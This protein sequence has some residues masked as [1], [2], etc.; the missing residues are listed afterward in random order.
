[1]AH[2]SKSV[3]QYILWLARDGAVTPM[4]L[5]KLV[6][7]SHGWMLGLHSQPLLTENAEAW[8]YGPVVP[9]VYHHYKRFGGNT[10]TDVPTSEPSGFTPEEQDLLQ[11]V[12]KTYGK[13]NG[14]QL[15]A[16]THQPG[17]PW[18]I[19]RRL[20]GQGAITPNDLIEEHYRALA[21]KS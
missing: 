16:L 10:I 5:L 12:W 7:L 9:S 13:Y 18:E 1:M 11:Q 20:S 19:T 8:Q 14:L 2:D 3:A 6:Y 15:S 4:Q 21:K 17:T